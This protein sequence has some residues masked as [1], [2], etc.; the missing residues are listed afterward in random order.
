MLVNIGFHLPDF[1]LKMSPV[2]ATS[3]L[4]KSP[5]FVF[6]PILTFEEKARPPRG[7]LEVA[8]SLVQK[9][10]IFAGSFLKKSHTLPGLL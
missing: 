2:F 10:P 5:L 9:G 8:G 3:L 6:E 7:E 4:K 1:F